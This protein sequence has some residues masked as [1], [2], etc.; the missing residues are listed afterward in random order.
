MANVSSW[1]GGGGRGG[2][3]TSPGLWE[4]GT[5]WVG[6][7][8]SNKTATLSRQDN[9]GGVSGHCVRPRVAQPEI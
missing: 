5:N 9:T 3:G 2:G 1:A 4:S 6:G 7:S 8:L